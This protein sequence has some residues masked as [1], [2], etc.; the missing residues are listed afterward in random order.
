MLKVQNSFWS[1][2]PRPWISAKCW[3]IHVMV[4]CNNM[5][6]TMTASPVI[7]KLSKF[8][9]WKYSNQIGRSGIYC[10]KLYINVE[11]NELLKIFTQKD[12][13]WTFSLVSATTL[14]LKISVLEKNLC[15]HDNSVSIYLHRNPRSNSSRNNHA[16]ASTDYR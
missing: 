3:N 7:K 15:F 4:T 8:R 1:L 10:Q 6:K 13:L 16:V 11:L 5:I 14:L 12:E 2:R 9:T